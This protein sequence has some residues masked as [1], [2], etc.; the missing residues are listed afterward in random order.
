M[1]IDGNTGLSISVIIAIV[2]SLVGLFGFIA[3]RD[4]RKIQE[5]KAQGVIETTL[6]SMNETLDAFKKSND[7]F[8]KE[9]REEHRELN[10]RLK[11]VE[12]D[13]LIMKNKPT[14]R[15]VEGT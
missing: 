2:G 12:E 7:V 4:A 1:P 9:H 8:Q 5:G 6:K 11:N 13:V 15:K 14:R 10:S 3:I